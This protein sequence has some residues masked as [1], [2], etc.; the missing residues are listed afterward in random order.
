[1][2]ELMLP[3]MKLVD[4]PGRG[5][6]FVSSALVSLILH[7]GLLVV[8]FWSPLRSA[9]EATPPVAIDVT[10]VP[11]PEV[12]SVTEPPEEEPAPDEPQAASAEP[13]AAAAAAS[14]GSPSETQPAEPATAVLAPTPLPRPGNRAAE[15]TTGGLAGTSN[16]PVAALEADS[17][18]ADGGIDGSLSADPAIA[19]LQLGDVRDADRFYLEAMLEDPGLAR[20]RET[21]QTLPADKRLSQT[22]NIEALAQIGYSGEGFAPDV[23]MTDAYAMSVAEGTRLSATGAIFRSQERWYGLAFDCTLS[24]DLTQVTSFSFRLGADVTDAVLERMGQR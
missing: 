5:G 16:E 6:W 11:P 1:M 17:G 10:L 2:S 24:N 9:M 3:E 21:L 7:A 18:E 22:C 13:A 19:A 4:P 14:A 12:E 20:A 23:V 8:V 15:G